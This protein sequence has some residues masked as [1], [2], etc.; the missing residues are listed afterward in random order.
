[1]KDK[2]KD[3][4]RIRYI[5]SSCS[6]MHTIQR[7]D[8][9]Y[10]TGD[11]WSRVLDMAKVYHEYDAAATTV[12]ALQYR[13]YRGLPVRAFK[14]EL[15]IVL[16]ADDV[17]TRCVLR[18]D[19]PESVRRQYFLSLILVQHYHDFLLAVIAEIDICSLIRREMYEL[20]VMDYRLDF[21]PVQ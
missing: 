9:A 10:W 8:F 15:S 6:R 20:A 19:L 14:M 2:H 21:S 18:K 17:S 13:Q 4:L 1:M 7:G 12:A 3:C 11:G 5:G 16:A